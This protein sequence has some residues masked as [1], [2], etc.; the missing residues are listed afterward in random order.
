MN[1]Q[2]LSRSS[3]EGRSQKTP[4]GN[5]ESQSEPG[6]ASPPKKKLIAMR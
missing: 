1:V 6:R 4:G 2:Q 5:V 3:V